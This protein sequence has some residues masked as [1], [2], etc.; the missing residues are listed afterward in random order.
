MRPFTLAQIPIEKRPPTQLKK[1]NSLPWSQ[2]QVLFWPLTLRKL[3]TKTEMRPWHSECSP[4]QVDSLNPNGKHH[5]NFYLPVLWVSKSPVVREGRDRRPHPFSLA[6]SVQQCTFGGHPWWLS[7]KRS[8]CQCRIEGFNPWSGK[9][10]HATEQLSPGATT[11][12]P[13]L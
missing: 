3:S 12:E 8:T 6:G 9:M 10:P 11:T 7:D 5:G 13:V 1:E 4:L 2:V